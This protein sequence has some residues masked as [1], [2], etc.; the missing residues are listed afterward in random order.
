M[1]PYLNEKLLFVITG[2][3]QRLANENKLNKFS[4]SL[5]MH[6]S[7]SSVLLHSGG[8]RKTIKYSRKSQLGESEQTK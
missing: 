6:T 5:L 2:N 1:T 8:C 3:K 7:L 4:D